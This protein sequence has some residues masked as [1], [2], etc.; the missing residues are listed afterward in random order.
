MSYVIVR[1]PKLN[2][3]DKAG[4][5]KLL[6]NSKTMS[7][8]EKDGPVLENKSRLGASVTTLHAGKAF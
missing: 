5:K 3:E 8:G 2:R 6:E 7:Q 4:H 1:C